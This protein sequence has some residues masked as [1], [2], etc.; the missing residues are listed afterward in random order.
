MVL[1]LREDAIPRAAIY[2]MHAL[3]SEGMDNLD[4]ITSFGEDWEPR[5]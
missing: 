2:Y 3:H 4:D 5:R 1:R